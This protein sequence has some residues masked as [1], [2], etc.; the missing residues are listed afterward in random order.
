M[1]R[2]SGFHRVSQAVEGAS[3]LFSAAALGAYSGAVGSEITAD[4]VQR[5]AQLLQDYNIIVRKGYGR[6]AVTDP[7]IQQNW[8]KRIAV[9]APAIH[10]Q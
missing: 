6:Y 2:F 5:I 8:C 4:Q 3:G 7:F 1:A 10:H 9:L